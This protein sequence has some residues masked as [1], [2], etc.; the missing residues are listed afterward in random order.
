MIWK[1]DPS[2][3]VK[4]LKN[5]DKKLQMKQVKVT[6]KII[7]K[8]VEAMVERRPDYF[9]QFAKQYRYF[10][11]QSNPMFDHTVTKNF[12]YNLNVKDDFCKVPGFHYDVIASNDQLPDSLK[13]TASKQFSIPC[14]FASC[15]L[16]IKTKLTTINFRWE[17]IKKIDEVV[18]YNDRHQLNFANSWEN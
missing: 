6:K 18:N 16:F 5:N 13:S 1:K 17:T 4:K 10:I 11:C 7:T 8:M 14:L 3:K 9:R 2:M 15:K 12:A